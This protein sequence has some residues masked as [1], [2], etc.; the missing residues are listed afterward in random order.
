[1]R[2][3]DMPSTVI[4]S[5]RYH[6][7]EDRLEITFVTGR[8]YNYYD[9]SSEVFAEMQSAYS[10]GEFFNKHIRDHFRFTREHDRKARG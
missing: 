1:M 6:P 9:V 8:R 4:R 7:A 2:Y 5:V 10:K 3:S